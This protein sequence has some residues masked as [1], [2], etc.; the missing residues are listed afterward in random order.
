MKRFRLFLLA[1]SLAAPLAA[2]PAT[3]PPRESGMP[4]TVSV[5][6]NSR[7]QLT[8][9]RFSFNVGVQTMAPTVDDA[10]NQNNAR[11]A[12]VIAALKKAGA[13][14]AEVRTSGFSVSPQQ[15]YEPGQPPR[16]VGYQVSNSVTV[17]KK[18]VA[19]AGRLLQVA[20]SAGVNEASG[21]MFDVADQTRG[22][23]QG[24]RAAFDDARAKAGLLAQAAGRTL[25]RAIMITEGAEPMAPRPMMMGRAMAAKAEVVSQVPVESGSSELTYTVSVVF[26]MR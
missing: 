18:E 14:D 23:D 20:I 25:G 10:V 15:T 9:D 22:R 21:L 12:S 6:G 7:V 2:Q 3:Q 24:L 11:V 26:E 8:P 17:T 4:E 1:T 13:T 5:T 16:L 19:Q